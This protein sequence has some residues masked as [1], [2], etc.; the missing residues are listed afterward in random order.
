MA[1]SRPISLLLGSTTTVS[2]PS[3]P[4]GKL[5]KWESETSGIVVD[6]Y[7]GGSYIKVLP[8]ENA[9]VGY[10]IKNTGGVPGNF[11]NWFVVRFDNP[12]PYMTDQTEISDRRRNSRATM[13]WL[14]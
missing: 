2:L 5:P 7:D 9:I 13:C 12:M 3:C 11:R 4:S 10:T 6:A 14:R 1:S 8:E